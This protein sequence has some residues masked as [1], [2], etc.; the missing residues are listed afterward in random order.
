MPQAHELL[1]LHIEK[2]LRWQANIDIVLRKINHY[3]FPTLIQLT[4]LS[5]QKPSWDAD[6]CLETE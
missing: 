1:D 2:V 4:E 6:S 3:V 5:E